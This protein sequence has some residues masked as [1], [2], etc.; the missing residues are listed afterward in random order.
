MKL[1]AHQ[2]PIVGVVPCSCEIL[3]A[4]GKCL[5][6]SEKPN[7]PFTKTLQKITKNLEIMMNYANSKKTGK[8]S[9]DA[10]TFSLCE[11]L[12]EAEAPSA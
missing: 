7:H 4:G 5:F 10:I 6:A 12:F 3:A 2:L 8:P 1:A 9:T 11:S